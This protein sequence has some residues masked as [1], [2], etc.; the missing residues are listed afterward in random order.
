MND[1]LHED[2]KRDAIAFSIFLVLIAGMVYLW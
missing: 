1:D 2:R